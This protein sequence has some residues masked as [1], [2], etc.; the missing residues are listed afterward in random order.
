MIIIGGIGVIL[1]MID[2][3]LIIHIILSILTK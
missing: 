2:I 3:V 1:I